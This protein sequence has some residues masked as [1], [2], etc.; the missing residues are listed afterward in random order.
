[1][2]GRTDRILQAAKVRT[3][4]ASNR[5][6]IF[7]NTDGSIPNVGSQRLVE[8]ARGGRVRD[9]RLW[10]ELAALTGGSGNST[11][12]VGTGE[13]IAESLLDYYDLGITSFLIRG[14]DPLED[15]IA[16]GREIIPLVRAAVA[17]R[18]AARKAA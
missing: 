13:Q 4:G 5:Q 7:R 16:Y 18:D 10:T 11:G 15:T 6:A 17:E 2:L 9:K 14:F 1:M 8:A 3:A 12:L